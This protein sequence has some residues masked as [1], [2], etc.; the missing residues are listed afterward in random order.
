LRVAFAQASEKMKK[1]GEAARDAAL[2]REIAKQR[3]N[4][5]RFADAHGPREK[6]AA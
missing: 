6:N 3:D 2:E 5:V 1:V 4:E